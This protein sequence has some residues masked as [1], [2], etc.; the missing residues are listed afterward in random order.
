MKNGTT[1]LRGHI[2]ICKKHPHSVET[3]QTQLNLH[4]NVQGGNILST[5]KFDQIAGRNALAY[6]IIVDELPFKFV[7]GLGFEKFISVVQPRF[8]IPSRFTV[9][10]DYYELFLAEIVKLKQFL[11]TTSQRVCLTTNT[12]TSIQRINHMCLTAHFI[13]N[14]WNEHKK[15]FFVQLIVIRVRI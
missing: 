13:G 5:W 2:T 1:T 7:E 10:R 15:I 12:W 11:K 4:S 6:M 9:S 8:K 3:S 14:D